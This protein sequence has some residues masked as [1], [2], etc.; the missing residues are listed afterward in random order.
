KPTREFGEHARLKEARRLAVILAGSDGSAVPLVHPLRW[1]GSWHRKADPAR[2]ARIVDLRADV[3][4]DLDEAFDRLTNA[5]KAAPHANG[6]ARQRPPR[7]G[8]SGKPDAAALDINAAL[9]VISN[10]D[11]PEP[12]QKLFGRTDP[13]GLAHWADWNRIGMAIWRASGGSEAGLA[14]F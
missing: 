6:K 2:L 9:A 8:T 11:Q 3:E 5:V 4:I 14:A 7:A 1:P 10:D 13:Q 12:I